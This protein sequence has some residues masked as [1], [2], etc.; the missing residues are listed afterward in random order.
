MLDRMESAQLQ[1]INLT[2]KEVIKDHMQFLVIL[3]ISV[4]CITL[5]S[6]FITKLQQF[7]VF[8]LYMNLSLLNAQIL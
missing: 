7:I 4:S 2:D 3:N 5:F 8:D 1:T 6:V